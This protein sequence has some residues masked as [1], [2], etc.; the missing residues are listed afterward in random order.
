[1]TNQTQF[2]GEDE[3]AGFATPVQDI[4]AAVFLA[5]LSLWIMIESL[6]MGSSH[7]LSTAPGLLPF[8][9]AGSLC[10]MAA[11]LFFM[12]MKRRAS[13]EIS[14]SQDDD[15]P[16]HV[17]TAL[18]V[19]FIG[20]Y[21]LCLQYLGFEYTLMVGGAELGYG[22]FEVLT[23]LFLT[24][25]LAVFWGQAVWQCLV[26]SAVWVTLLAAAFRYVFVIPLPGSI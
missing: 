3:N 22:A 19:A 15:K 5:V 10:A 16:D 1:M 21:L 4:I 13:G 8:L 24:C 11:T 26:I 9:T 6:Q 17:R 12:A 2:S 25:I 23:I 20:V 18:L 14:T 7:S